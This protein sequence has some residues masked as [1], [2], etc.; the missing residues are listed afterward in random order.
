MNYSRQREII[1]EVLS[2]NAIHPTAEKLFQLIKKNHP[3]SNIGIATVYRNLS[4]LADLGIIKRITG[5]DEAEHFDHN[6]HAHYHLLCK[7]CKNI[8]DIEEKIQPDLIKNIQKKTGFYITNY[9]IIFQ[10]FCKKCK[11]N[12]L[13]K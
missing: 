11:S 7:K 1:L 6:T 8:Y 9:D 3:E 4:K 5:L 13:V 2:K 10:G 12:K